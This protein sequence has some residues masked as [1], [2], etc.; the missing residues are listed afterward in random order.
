MPFD[1]VQSMLSSVQQQLLSS[2]WRIESVAKN[3]GNNRTVW[4]RCVGL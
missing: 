2:G 3:R 1:T 4:A